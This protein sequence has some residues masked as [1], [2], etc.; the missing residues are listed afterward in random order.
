MFLPWVWEGFFIS[1][2]VLWGRNEF[3]LGFLVCQTLFYLWTLFANWGSKTAWMEI[4]HMSTGCGEGKVLLCP[5]AAC[6]L[7]WSALKLR[8]HLHFFLCSF[9][10]LQSMLTHLQKGHTNQNHPK[11]RTAPSRDKTTTGLSLKI[12]VQLPLIKFSGV[13]VSA[14]KNVT[15]K[16]V[17]LVHCL[18]FTV[19]W[20]SLGMKL[21][22]V[23]N[24]SGK[25]IG[26]YG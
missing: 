15:V 4:G 16:L 6:E 5:E 8:L 1:P 25:K 21:K 24:S 14:W 19:L 26:V 2:Q 13:H 23:E 20:P 12:K 17:F 10:S 11:S 3:S 9:L 7:F 22:K 18:I